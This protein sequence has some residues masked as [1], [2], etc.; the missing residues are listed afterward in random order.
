[1]TVDNNAVKN[2]TDVPEKELCAGTEQVIV[3]DAGKMTMM[4]V[5]NVHAIA[6]YAKSDATQA[7][8]IA[9]RPFYES[10]P[11]NTLIASY[12]A[13]TAWA[14]TEIIDINDSEVAEFWRLPYSIAMGMELALMMPD[15][16]KGQEYTVLFDG[17]EYSGKTAE[18]YNTIVIGSNRIFEVFDSGITVERD[19]IPFGIII[20][21]EG[22]Y[23]LI[24]V[25]YFDSVT[26]D[27]TITL[28]TDVTTVH[29]IDCKYFPDGYPYIEK[30]LVLL[31]EYNGSFDNTEH[32]YIEQPMLFEPETD[33]DSEFIF[34]VDDEPI[35]LSMKDVR[36]IGEIMYFG[37]GGL[38]DEEAGLPDTG[39]DFWIYFWGSYI[40]MA[41]RDK[42]NEHSIS[43][44]GYN[45]IYHKIDPKLVGVNMSEY[46]SKREADNTFLLSDGPDQYMSRNRLSPD[47]VQKYRI[48]NLITPSSLASTYITKDDMA[49]QY[50]T[51]EAAD[52]RY[53]T[54]DDFLRT[55][56]STYLRETKKAGYFHNWNTITTSSPIYIA[57]KPYYKAGSFRRYYSSQIRDLTS[58]SFFGFMSYELSTI[59]YS[60]T[61]V[62]RFSDNMTFSSVDNKIVCLWKDVSNICTFTPYATEINTFALENPP[63]D[64]DNIIGLMEGERLVCIEATTHS[65]YITDN[66][67]VYRYD[68]FT[69]HLINTLDLSEYEKVMQV[70]VHPS[71]DLLV[72]SL[73]VNSNKTLHEVHIYRVD[74]D[75]YTLLKT[76]YG[77]TEIDV[78]KCTAKIES[79]MI[80][81]CFNS[82]GAR[83]I[84]AGGALAGGAAM[85]DVTHPDFLEM[86][87]LGL[88]M[89]KDGYV[90]SSKIN[91]SVACQFDLDDDNMLYTNNGNGIT[92]YDLSNNRFDT[93]CSSG[94]LSGVTSVRAY[95]GL[96]L[97]GNKLYK[98]VN[99][100]IKSLGAYSK[101]G[102]D[103][104]ALADDGTGL[105]YYYPNIYVVKERF[106]I[107]YP[108]LDNVKDMPKFSV[109]VRDY[110]QS[111][112]NIL[113]TVDKDAPID[114]M[115]LKS[116]TPG[117]DKKFR[118]SIGSDGQL[119][120]TEYIEE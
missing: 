14:Q 90:N 9:N 40:G 92:C 54:D 104:M 105:G 3:N 100:Q 43:L 22:N 37:N 34:I 18:F 48:N 13:S 51:R 4:P 79:L 111:T 82:K 98:V 101:I 7:G 69:G 75:G 86:C 84:L 77:S 114:G 106:G 47:Y 23:T 50:M 107:C 45:N 87:N 115:I 46:F 10:E 19:D 65:L 108:S 113:D 33:L 2:I 26:L 89:Y 110:N 60:G 52:N 27:H 55:W 91:T 76:I 8:F 53:V 57:N 63:D 116:C 81:I 74:D 21:Y 117:S 44:F 96:V 80:R 64:P 78:D 70:A 24:E 15:I 39:E 119:T 35:T 1:M 42:E 93:I 99:R 16:H 41:L 95:K 72:V 12:D 112:I 61:P 71:G 66:K 6:D 83:M 29:K 20:A 102:F 97:A 59:S 17:E 28:L 36:V 94:Y 109:F 68:A 49:S 118:I 31:F 103:E 120:T 25:L 38:I 73:N 67:I 30:E 56:D 32:G 58:A 11:E 88:P 5:E 85:Y 62:A